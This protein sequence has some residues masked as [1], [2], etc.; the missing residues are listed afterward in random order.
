M[1][2]IKSH[3]GEDISPLIFEYLINDEDYT[4]F[5]CED[6]ISLKNK[7]TEWDLCLY[8]AIENN[9][10]EIFS[11][12]HLEIASEGFI[13]EEM[14]DKSMHVA[15]KS[16]NI[17][18][19]NFILTVCNNMMQS[20]VARSAGIGGYLHMIQMIESYFGDLNDFIFLGAGEGGHLDIF[21]TYLA[22]YN[23][24]VIS[25]NMQYLWNL[26]I[27][28]IIKEYHLHILEWIGEHPEKIKYEVNWKE[29]IYKS[30]YLNRFGIFK[31]S[32]S[33]ISG[34]T[35]DEWNDITKSCIC[36]NL[37]ID[38]TI[39]PKN[40]LK[41]LELIGERD[42]YK[43]N[44]TECMK[45]AADN[46]QF[47]IFKYSLSKGADI[48]KL[49]SVYIGRGGNIDILKLVEHTINWN[50][51]LR[52]A[53]QGKH[54]NIAKHALDKGADNW[55]ECIIESSENGNLS[56]FIIIENEIK[57]RNIYITT[58]LYNK[59]MLEA[60]RQGCI[61]IVKHVSEHSYNWNQCMKDAA[62]YRHL[63]ILKY[64]E[65]QGADDWKRT[66]IYITSFTSYNDEE[67][68]KYLKSKISLYERCGPTKRRK[69]I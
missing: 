42:E 49:H 4:P 54:P 12:I 20:G 6:I 21:I 58:S 38:G 51:C 13:T 26:M 64:A 37:L 50:D 45:D 62:Y 43:V 15:V 68:V 22:K 60:T 35:D 7:I 36:G 24:S 44:W 25:N 56:S 9:R 33:K 61:K 53:I 14:W 18:I 8:W 63:D 19:F 17:E 3:L 5:R 29:C 67:I 59:C 30:I 31:Y 1:E 69:L 28:K 48:T 52:G 55:E 32:L 39:I 40:A 65:S 23:P 2:H 11:Y 47:D 16:G 10:S 27:R 41:M 46:G 57:N 66:L 34:I